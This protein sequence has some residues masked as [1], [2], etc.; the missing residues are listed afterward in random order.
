M[1]NQ[2]ETLERM[3][4][5]CIPVSDCGLWRVVRVLCTER[6]REVWRRE[7]EGEPPLAGREYTSLLRYTDSTIHIGGETVMTDEP[8]EL[9]KHLAFVRAA[10]GDVLVTGLGLACVV[11]GLQCSPRVR[12]IT[13]VERDADVIRLVWPHT[14]HDRVTLI[15]ADANEFLCETSQRWDCAWH[16]IWTD[17][18]GGELHL[19]VAHQRL[20]IYAA[21]SVGFQGAWAFPRAHRRALRAAV[22]RARR[23]DRFMKWSDAVRSAM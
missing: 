16:D 18:D 10:R 19:A 1:L 11:R 23:A 3:R 8:G 9:R 14:S 6:G 22:E 2:A 15:E 7:C 5:D 12:S 13:V 21:R 4:A 20:M 17:R